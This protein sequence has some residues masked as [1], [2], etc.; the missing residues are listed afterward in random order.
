MDNEKIRSGTR[1]KA[2]SEMDVRKGQVKL[3]LSHE[4]RTSQL[5]SR[6]SAQHLGLY[7]VDVEF[8][9]VPRVSPMNFASHKSFEE[10]L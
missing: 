8:H 4:N 10:L 9:K 3:E 5:L 6:G 7:E 1:S 2:P